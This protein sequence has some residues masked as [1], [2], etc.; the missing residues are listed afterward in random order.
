MI[1]VVAAPGAVLV[2]MQLNTCHELAAPTGSLVASST[3]PRACVPGVVCRNQVG[4]NVDAIR[5]DRQLCSARMRED[6]LVD[7]VV[8][9]TDFD[10]G[11]VPVEL[12]VAHESEVA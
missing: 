1:R 2:V 12:G 4:R 6:D 10:F 9:N 5:V 3:F 7:G 8:S 11:I